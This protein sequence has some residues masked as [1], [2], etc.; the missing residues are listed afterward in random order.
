MKSQS[1]LKTKSMTIFNLEMTID[2]A[3]SLYHFRGQISYPDTP[4]NRKMMAQVVHNHL[5][6]LHGR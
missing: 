3:M 2:E 4:H 6:K 1:Q 5:Q